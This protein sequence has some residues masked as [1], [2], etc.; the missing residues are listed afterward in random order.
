MN[1]EMIKYLIDNLEIEVDTVT[2]FGP[3][4]NIVV[5]LKLG[6]NVISQDSCELPLNYHTD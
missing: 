4:D 3:V 6:D 1:E 2:E 5:T